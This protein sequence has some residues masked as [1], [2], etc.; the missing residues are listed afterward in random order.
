LIYE[1]NLFLFYDLTLHITCDKCGQVEFKINRFTE[2]ET[3]MKVFTNDKPIET[4]LCADVNYLSE[5]TISGL[6]PM[7]MALCPT[8]HLHQ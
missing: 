6:L 5:I 2:K 7:I 1:F 4:T 3:V 8:I